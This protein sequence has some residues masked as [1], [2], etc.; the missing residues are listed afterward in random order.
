MNQQKIADSIFRPLAPGTTIR[1]PS[2]RTLVLLR[3]IRQRR[4]P[5]I[6]WLC[7]YVLGRSTV[8]LTEAFIRAYA[9]EVRE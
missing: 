3:R 8:V 9:N 2:G 7:G 6:D 1:L 5:N 4:N